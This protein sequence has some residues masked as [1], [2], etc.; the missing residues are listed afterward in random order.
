MENNMACHSC[1][2]EAVGGSNCCGQGHHRHFL[3]RMILGIV[4]L[5][6]VFSVG[7][8]IGEFKGEFENNGFGGY[9][10]MHGQ[11]QNSYPMDYNYMMNGGLNQ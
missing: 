6:I 4:I 5:M 3:L 7:V 2:Q 1:G 11:Y 8:K 10:M 9:R